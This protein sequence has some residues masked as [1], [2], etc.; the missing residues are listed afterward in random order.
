MDNPNETF[1]DDKLIHKRKIARMTQ[2]ATAIM[3]EDWVSVEE[4][5]T[6][7]GDAYKSVDL[8]FGVADANE[9]ANGFQFPSSVVWSDALELY[10]CDW[11]LSLVATKKNS[12][13]IN[14]RFSAERLNALWNRDDPDFQLLLELAEGVPVW[15][16]ND[17]IPAPNP[18]PLSRAY[19]TVSAVINK[20][21]YEQWERGQAI[22]LPLSTL[23][24]VRCT[25]KAQISFSGKYGWVPKHGSRE[26]RPTNNYS[27]DNGKH[28]LINSEFVKHAVKEFYG[29]IELAQ[30]E[31]LMR[32]ILRQL[33]VA[34]GVWEDIVLWKMDLK[35]AFALLNF[36]VNEIGLL[37][38]VLTEDLCFLSLVGNFGLSQFPFIFGVISRVL[39]R[40][41]NSEIQGEMNIFVDD[42]LGV[43][44]KKFL[45]E[46]MRIAKDVAERLLGKFAISAKK[47]HHGPILD[48][49]GW[50]VNLLT[51]TVTIANHNLYKT[52]YGFFKLERGQR[53]T[54]KE[55]QRLASWASRY[56]LICRY[57]RP[58][59]Y[60]LYNA[61]KGRRQLQALIP[62]DGT[63]WMVIQLWQ[64]FLV[65]AKLR[66]ENF[67]KTIISF[68][69]PRAAE[70]WISYD[71][72]LTG[73]GFIIRGVDP[74]QTVNPHHHV[75]SAVSFDTPYELN[76]DSG[77]QNTMEFLAILFA[78]YRVKRLGYVDTRV[79]IIGDNTSSLHWCDKE[80]FRGGRSN[81]PA[82]AYIILGMEAQNEIVTSSF[83]K[84]EENIHCDK[85]SRGIRP[86]ALG[87]SKEVCWDAHRDKDFVELVRLVD[88]R[89][90]N[91]EEGMLTSLWG[92]LK[93]LLGN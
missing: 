28:G 33:E 11:D 13:L 32:M 56:T 75:I 88:P 53:I 25:G 18:P 55:V 89:V 35:G 41:I 61:V 76:G 49:I 26:G 80:R 92:Q 63:L 37:T 84:G 10:N 21:C 67:A 71:A 9:W 17:F 68:G 39:L 14:D 29:A 78:M 90:E 16:S 38:M 73:V 6:I 87:Y 34:T 12:V 79:H 65:V 46:D 36:K 64:I 54:V 91:M 47:T 82:L 22:I 59:T 7:M 50:E 58:F 19:K 44:Q 60:Y 42:F 24:D 23:T 85:M 43:T 69:V 45:E 70:L 5:E 72:S 74:S 93:T 15:R 52:L 31:E 4:V 48:W 1:L 62:V 81:S 27:Y 40:A 83:I 86:R 66:P 3:P 30:L 2:L 20:L 8:E 51:Q 77:F 57:M